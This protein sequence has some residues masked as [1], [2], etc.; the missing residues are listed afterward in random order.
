MDNNEIINNTNSYDY[1]DEEIIIPSP[2]VQ[3]W[4]Y[5]IFQIPSL[6]C[7]LYLLYYL[8]LNRKLRIQLNNHVVIVL[9]VLCFIILVIDHSLYLDAWRIVHGNSFPFSSFLCLFW[10]YI[11]Y[12]FYGAV[13][14]FLAWA[15]FERHILIFYRRQLLNT[16]RKIFYIHYFPLI[17][18]LIYLISFYIGIIFFPPCINIFYSNYLACGSY[19][20]YQDIPWINTWDYL[21]NGILPNISEAFFT[22]SLVFRVI[23]RR[24]YSFR[25]FNWIKYRKMIIQLLAMSTLSLSIILPQSLISLIQQ[26]HPTMSNFGIEAEP[27]LFYLTGYIILFLPF[28]CLGSLPELWP[29]VFFLCQ[30]RQHRVRPIRTIAANGGA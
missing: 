3:F 29:K 5:L 2:Q 27:Y 8:L 20:C 17:I 23:W 14:V 7:I 28:V 22:I 9:L 24:Y 10:W 11:D 12:G 21:L 30:K 16:Q 13:Y 25:H 6:A 19:P 26:I 18:I 15:S 1:E 4:T